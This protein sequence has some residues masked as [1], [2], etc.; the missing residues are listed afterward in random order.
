[1]MREQLANNA[2]DSGAN[3]AYLVPPG[4]ANGGRYDLHAGSSSFP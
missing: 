3:T 1:L 2:S 4:C